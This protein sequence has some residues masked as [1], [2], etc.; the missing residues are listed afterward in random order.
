MTEP[1]HHM[2]LL[3]AYPPGP[4]QYSLWELTVEATG[5]VL[6]TDLMPI[7]ED[8]VRKACADY[9]ARV[10]CIDGDLVRKAVEGGA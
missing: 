7:D 9:R 8:W 6:A 4:G 1:N 10:G 2:F 5:E 3:T